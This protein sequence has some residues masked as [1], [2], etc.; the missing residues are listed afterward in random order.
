[1]LKRKKLNENYHHLRKSKKRKY[2]SLLKTI[3]DA[4]LVDETLKLISFSCLKICPIFAL[5][6]NNMKNGDKNNAWFLWLSNLLVV[7]K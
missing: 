3:K 2:L 1:M 6:M 5:E 4:P 7:I